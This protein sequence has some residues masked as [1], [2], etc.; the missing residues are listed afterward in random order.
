MGESLHDLLDWIGANPGWAYLAVLLAAFAESLA[1]IG[2]IVPGVM[3][4]IGAGALIATGDLRFWPTCL[5]AVA[6]AIAGD[7]LSFW[8]GHRYRERIRRAWP[9]CRHSAQLDKGIAFFEHHGAKSVVLGRFF[10]PVRAIV[11]LVA[12]IMHMPPRQ[13]LVVNIGSALAWAPAYLAPGIVFGASLKLAAEA[14]SRLTILLLVLVGLLWIGIWSAHRLYRVFS[15]RAAKW[16]HALLRWAAVHP[17][18]GRVAQA[19]ADPSHPDTATLTALAAALLG[20]TAMLGLSIGAGLIGAPHL[21]LNRMALDLGQSLHSPLADDLMVV[22]SHLG[23]PI[24]VLS[25]SAGVL[26]FLL[27]RQR[28]RDAHYWVAACAFALVATPILAWLLQVPRPELGLNLQWPWSFPSS[29]VLSATLAYGFLAI[30]LSRGITE[31]GRWLPYAGATV[32]VLSVAL[33]RLYFGAEW[34]SDI[35]GS[36]ALGLAWISALGLAFRRHSR[37]EPRWIGLALVAALSAGGS[38]TLSSLERH[39]VD[40]ERYRPQLP[41]REI[42][43]AQWRQRQCELWPGHREGLWRHSHEQPIDLAYAGE[44]EPFIAAMS[45]RGWQPADRLAWSNAMKLLSPSLP[46]SELPVVPQVHDGRHETLTLIKDEGQKQRMV[47]RLW[48]SHCGIDGGIPVWIGTLTV[49][50]KESIANLL[51]LPITMDNA[52]AARMTFVHDLG[53]TTNFTLDNGTPMLIA[54][55]GSGL[56]SN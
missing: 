2:V 14:T 46:L 9:F 36:L 56:L 28:W 33:A 48:V 18:L 11:P 53:A 52:E 45:A 51:A 26:G 20:A 25:L 23:S 54:T 31:A 24:V 21:G 37:E 27:W 43:V 39:K 42:S 12:G 29:S 13:F 1:V 47:L 32:T 38:L 34:L 16:V 40:L 50:R 49:L 55:T 22:L 15:P 19:L 6:G 5:S 41:S 4:M 10:G 30:M 35:V 8:I 44:L 17:R 3:I 7:G